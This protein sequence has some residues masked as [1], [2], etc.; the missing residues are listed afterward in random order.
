MYTHTYTLQ[1][2]TTP[3]PRVRIM[4]CGI[5]VPLFSK[6]IY[7]H[8]LVVLSILL[9]PVIIIITIFLL[10]F[11]EYY[12]FWC[13]SL[14]RDTSRCHTLCLFIFFPNSAWCVYVIPGF[15]LINVPKV[16][17]AWCNAMRT[18]I[19]ERKSQHVNISKAKAIQAV[20]TLL[21]CLQS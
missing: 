19:V 5:I 3:S 1:C 18:E 7:M 8:V 11:R 15:W 17:T 2:N 10:S 9:L 16:I 12:F 20:F 4:G 14:L 6:N 21:S 13:A